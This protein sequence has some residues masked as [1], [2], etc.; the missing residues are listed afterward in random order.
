[1]VRGGGSDDP[2]HPLYRTRLAFVALALGTIV[3]GLAL[4][5]RG[6][7]LP[8]GI[9]DPVGDALWAMMI[10]WWTGA[11]VP[12]GGAVARAVVALLV[13][14]AVEF[15]QLVHAAL[16]DAWRETTM[17]HLILGSDFDARDLVAYAVGVLI[18][19][20]LEMVV[21]RRAPRRT[22]REVA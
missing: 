20:G 9:G 2:T 4:R 19:C 5:S 14:W 16:L 13:C 6:G 3:V 7:L 15:S 11:L 1:M 22:T 21:R 8:R 12:A 10:F 17:G 18:A